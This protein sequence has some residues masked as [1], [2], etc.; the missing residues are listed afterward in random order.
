MQITQKGSLYAPCDGE[1]LSVVKMED[2]K[3]SMEIKHNE[4]FKTV[5]K[6][7]DHAYFT[8][9]DKVYSTIPVGYTDGKD[10]VMCFYS[11]DSMISD[12]TIENGEVVWAV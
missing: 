9:G 5:L 10:T 2:G 3:F 4:N 12:Y 8:V 7:I 6:G 11:G 1:I